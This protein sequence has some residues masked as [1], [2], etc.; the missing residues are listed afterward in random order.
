MME[1]YTFVDRI[2]FKLLRQLFN[3]FYL[4]QFLQDTPDEE[5]LRRQAKKYGFD[6]EAYLESLRKFPVIPK[7]K[8]E[9]LMECFSI[10][11][12]ILTGGCAKL[13]EQLMN[14][15]HRDSLTGLYNR[16]YYVKEMQRLE[17][18]EGISV[19]IIMGDIDGLKLVNDTLGHKAGDEIL[20]IAAETLKSCFR[21]NDLAAR[22][23]GDEF[24]II[25]P[26]ANKK[27]L[28]K[29]VE[30]IRAEIRNYNLKNPKLPL[31]LSIGFAY[32]SKD[33]QTGMFDLFKQAENNMYREKLTRNQSMRSAIVH[34]LIKTMEARDHDTEKHAER[35]IVLITGFAREIN[36]PESNF[37][38]LLLL[39]QFHDIG[40][41]GIPD[42]ILLKPGP[43]TLKER[44]QMQSHS[45]I[46]FR[47]AQ[48]SNDLIMIAEL[49]LNHHEWWN[50][51]GYP[52]GLKEKEIPLCCRMLAIADAFDAM[53][54]DRPYRKAM[55]HEQ[56]VAELIRFKGIQFDPELVDRFVRSLRYQS[57]ESVNKN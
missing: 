40:K 21:E 33:D 38:L 9:Q 24:S 30:K 53:T 4:T 37:A 6:E 36:L 10:F 8:T 27:M 57:L 31:S 32:K 52:S 55:S 46:G 42:R 49:I 18:S 25:L 29:A 50:G 2:D 44:M 28:G 48:A 56:A 51:Q 20:M 7:D 1:E 41:I 34:T 12:R 47:I 3:T 19:G 15:S 17:E 54:S 5:F 26:F 23:G 39:A 22:I 43:L 13:N 16:H 45:E 35:L 11:C 14:L